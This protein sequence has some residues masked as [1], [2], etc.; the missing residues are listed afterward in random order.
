MDLELDQDQVALAG[1]VR[2]VLAREWPA[3]A[4]RNLVERGVGA[5]GLWARMIDLDWPALCV[6]QGAG[7]LGYGAVEANLVHEGCGA[8][9]VPGPLFA[10][11]ALFAPVVRALGSDRQRT[12]LLGAVSRGSATGTAA[13]GALP[14]TGGDEDAVAGALTATAVGDGDGWRLSGTLHAVIEGGGVDRIVVPAAIRSGGAVR[15]VVAFAV[16]RTAAGVVTEP[17]RA[18]DRTR[19]LATVHLRDVSMAASDVLG[20]GAAP[21]DG[22]ALRRAVDESV[23]ALAAELVG[24]CSTIFD[25]TLAHAKTRHQ[26]G[27]PIGSFQAIKHRLADAYLAL[28]AARAAVLVAGAAI[29]EDD[30]RRTVAASTAKALAGDAAGLLCAEGIQLLGGI[31]FTWDHDMHLHVKRAM[32][33]SALLG[34]AE[35]HRQRVATLIGLEGERT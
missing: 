21:G 27:V 19:R 6:P 33:S 32:G 16:D 31:G 15:D 3:V 28:E 13:L 26:F 4:L 18:Q 22:A 24:T 17:V 29:A 10:T 20:A 14:T 34:S 23:T 11:T 2:D 8:A 35:A 30:A 12:E 25:T 9:I 7:G 5:E 1:S